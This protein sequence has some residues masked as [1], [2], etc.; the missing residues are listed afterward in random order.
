LTC[1][2]REAFIEAG[3]DDIRLSFV[4]AYP[5]YVAAV[6]AS[7]GIA[8]DEVLGD[9]IVEGSTVLDGLLANLEATELIEQSSSPLELFREALRPI[10]RALALVGAPLPPS[11]SGAMRIAPWDRYALSPGSSQVLGQRARDAHIAWGLG[12]AQAVA[13]HVD[14]T[15][16]PV[17]GLL[18]P[19]GDLPDLVAEAEALHYRTTML[20]SDTDVSVAVVCADEPDADAVVRMVSQRARVIVYGRSMDD[21]DQVRFTAMG[22]SSAVDAGRLFGRLAEYIPVIG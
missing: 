2:D 6:L 14:S 13:R 18:C 19:A 3:Q 8:V 22:A 10:D 4:A 5:R 17:V 20:P 9:A 7:R 16:G 21:L 1:D 15:Q 11:G 12:K